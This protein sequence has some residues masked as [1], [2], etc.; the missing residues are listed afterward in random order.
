MFYN[1]F[2]SL[3]CMAKIKF[4]FVVLLVLPPQGESTIAQTQSSFGPTFEDCWTLSSFL[5]NFMYGTFVILIVVGLHFELAH[6]GR[7]NSHTF[8]WSHWLVPPFFWWKFHTNVKNKN[9]CIFTFVCK[10]PIFLRTKIPN[11][12][13]YKKATIFLLAS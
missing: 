4:L 10:F 12:C 13:T 2:W 5:Y 6:K 3:L 8:F 9:I 1:W 7:F 11:V